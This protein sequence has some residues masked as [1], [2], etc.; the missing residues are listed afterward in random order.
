MIKIGTINNFTVI[1]QT[2]L[3]YMIE[4]LNEEF[5]LHNN[6]TQG[7]RPEI[8]EVL[9]AFLYYD[10]KGRVAA[11]LQIP[12]LTLNEIGFVDVVDV[13]SRL[14]VFV[15][16]G[17]QK[18]LLVS[19]DDLPLN[20]NHWPV[21]GDK[22]L[23]EMIEKNRLVGKPVTIGQIKDDVKYNLKENDKVDA[24]VIRISEHGLNAITLNKDLIF[25]HHTQLR[26]TYR[27]GELIEVTITNAFDDALHGT[28]I[29]QKEHMI[30]LD[31]ET[32]LNYLKEH[33][34]VNLTNHSTP[35][36]IKRIFTMSKK[37]FKRAVGSL[38]KQDLIEFSDTSIIYKGEKNE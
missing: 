26:K 10:F 30:D 16:I 34:K 1:R 32:I 11:T 8:G 22:L 13:N 28:L 37:A 36:A 14:G 15:D 17:I 31:S 5:F 20:K 35:E 9:R 33:G 23:I 6:E 27:L 25:I 2:D 19:K 7:A 3:G 29:M 4:A 18:D 12:T 21:K 38:Y 24:Y